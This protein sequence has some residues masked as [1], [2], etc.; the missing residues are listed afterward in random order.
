M[1][2]GVYW[3]CGWCATAVGGHL[4]VEHAEVALAKHEKSCQSLAWAKEDREAPGA[5]T[6]WL[7]DQ[8]RRLYSAR[9]VVDISRP[10][11]GAA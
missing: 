4:N 11:P 1:S 10:P 3:K 2:N 5:I 6:T 9:P 7:D 8:G